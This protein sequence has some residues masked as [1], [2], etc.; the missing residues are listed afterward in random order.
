M[1]FNLFLTLAQ[2]R[3]RT[4]HEIRFYIW[5]ME[6][7]IKHQI[8]ANRWVR[9]ILLAGIVYFGFILPDSLST[10][11]KIL[12][13]SAHVGMSFFVAVCMYVIC[14]IMLNLSKS[15]SLL[16]LTFA[17]LIIGAIYK[18]MEI[19]AEGLLGSYL[20]NYGLAILLKATGCYTSMSQNMAGLLA[21]VFLM[22]YMGSYF[23]TR[24][25]IVQ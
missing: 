1:D 14:N 10:H 12:H 5:Q 3:V 11:D 18:Y 13:F 21:A 16:I 15:R 9:A 2:R 23:R 25:H 6:T 17:T 24:R 8:V 20:H 22:E 4:W 7:R 19:S